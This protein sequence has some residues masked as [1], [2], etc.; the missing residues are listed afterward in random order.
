MDEIKQH[1]QKIDAGGQVIS[2]TPEQLWAAAADY[3]R[4]CDEHPLTA[5]RALT[6]GKTQG[7]TYEVEFVRPYTVKGMCLHCNISEKYIDD[8][9]KNRDKEVVW[10]NVL[11]KILYIIHTQN[12]E[13]A[14]VDL[15]NPIMVSKVLN[16]DKQKSAD[17]DDKPVTVH[18]IDSRSNSLA[19]SENEILE[20]LDFGKVEILKDK[21]ENSKDK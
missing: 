13:G 8:I 1:W 4:W 9:V 20:K 3:F 19:K 14:I 7:K 18:V 10:Y 6:S 21:V 11:E 2:N 5:K 15:Y 12:L 17:E 16:L